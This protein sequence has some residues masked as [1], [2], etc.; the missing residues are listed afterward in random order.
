VLMLQRSAGNAAVGRLLARQPAR[1][2]TVDPFDMLDEEFDK[3][4]ENAEATRARELGELRTRLLAPLD[5]ND[6]TGFLRALRGL[7]EAE[8]R[9]L[10]HDDG[11]W[12]AIRRRFRG[13]ALWMIQLTIE[14]GARKP[15]DVRAVS[16]AIHSHDRVRT[17]NLVMAYPRLKSVVGI[18]EAVASEFE[19]R[20]NEDLQA[21]LR[22]HAGTRAEAAGLGGKRVH[23]EDGELVMY[24][25]GGAFELVR[26]N[27]HVR[28]IVRIRL[29]NDSDNEHNAITDK[30]IGRWERGIDRYW[31]GKFRLRNGAQALD[32]HFVPV[33][34]FYD[35]KAHQKV[36]V[37]EDEGRS[38]RRK[39]HEDDSED[40]AAHEFGH[41]LGNADE[42][43]LPATM[44]EIPAELGLSDEDKRRSSWEGLFPGQRR[45]SVDEEGYDVKGLM[46]STHKNRSVE[47]RHAYWILKVFNDRLRRPG[48]GSWAVEK[49]R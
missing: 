4:L 14:Y 19:G 45:R 8:R 47:E 20:D 22:E 41:M 42:Y 32:V 37:I 40:T 34:V 1:P 18:R 27:T 11:F 26:M 23:Y 46:G 13:M 35:N 24:K 39:W 44:A 49:K 7:G 17:R 15:H 38:A 2:G 48:E 12:V 30:A 16:A 5:K 33:F 3:L 29:R 31:N 25:G 36:R 21:F 43:N 9:R 28:V 10:Q 6:A